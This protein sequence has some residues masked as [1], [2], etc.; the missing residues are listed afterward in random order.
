ML[1]SLS[2]STD[3]F[4]DAD[5][6]SVPVPGRILSRS[7]NEEIRLVLIKRFVVLY[8]RETPLGTDRFVN[9]QYIPWLGAK[10]VKLNEGD[11][12]FHPSH[13]LPIPHDVMPHSTYYVV[14]EFSLQFSPPSPSLTFTTRRSLLT[15][16]WGAS[17]SSTL[18]HS[19]A[20]A[21]F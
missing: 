2:H 15:T 5:W 6:L 21:F 9:R 1:L 11:T 10:S 4:G 20:S 19:A 16:S 3:S 7:T 13:Q 18:P 14:V 8:G 17:T 12:V